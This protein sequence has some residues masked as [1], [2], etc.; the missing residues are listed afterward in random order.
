MMMII[1]IQYDGYG[2]GYGTITSTSIPNYAI[3]KGIA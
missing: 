2:N 1:P 3:I